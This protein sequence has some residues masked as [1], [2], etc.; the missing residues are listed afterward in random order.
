MQIV[1]TTLDLGLGTITYLTI[2]QSRPLESI[3]FFKWPKDG[4]DTKRYSLLS[5]IVGHLSPFEVDLLQVE[6][7]SFNIL[8]KLGENL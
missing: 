4:C 2:L 3:I 5:Y 8:G 1:K 7:L 6:K